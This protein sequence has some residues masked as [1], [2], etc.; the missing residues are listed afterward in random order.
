MRL[1]LN[2]SVRDLLYTAE[3]C[4]EGKNVRHIMEKKLFMSSRE[5]T[6][7]KQFGDG[8][9][10]KRGRGSTYS[11]ES[12][13][14]SDTGGWLHAFSG[15]SDPDGFKPVMIR[16]NVFC[17]DVLRIRIYED[18]ANE[19]DIAAN[20]IPLDIV[21]EDEDILVVNK[22]GDMVVHPSY[23]HYTDSLAGAVKGYYIRTSQNHVVRAIGR[24]DRETSGLV[25]FAKNR[26][27]AAILS[28]RQG[29]EMSKR[30]EYLALASGYF[31]VKQ[32]TIDAPIGETPGQRMVRCVT[33]DG[34]RAVTHFEVVRQLDDFALVRLFLE[35]GRT[36]QIRVHMSHMGH[37]LLGDGLYGKEIADSHGIT[38]AAL[39]AAHIE[40]THPILKKKMSFDADLP[41]NM[42]III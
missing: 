2:T 34:K 19:G 40:F 42:K 39:H 36:H 41:Q 22:P 10:I 26:Y 29:G 5:I 13:A 28:D 38:R 9:C 15:Q 4:D 11:S 3:A 21:Y 31:D 32:G 35:T 23:A 27:V 37:P 8:V 17:G 25:L 1:V 14:G 18:V 6:R 20:D 12:A 33:A 24:L 16:E 30:K 7:C